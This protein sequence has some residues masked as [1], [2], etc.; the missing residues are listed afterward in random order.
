[1]K[2]IMIIML[3]I[4]AGNVNA[5][6]FKCIVDGKSQYQSNPCKEEKHE[7][8]LPIRTRDI[9]AQLRAKDAERDFNLRQLEEGMLEAEIAQRRAAAI[10]EAAW[11]QR[12][13][14]EAEARMREAEAYER[15]V[16]I[17]RVASEAR[18][19]YLYKEA[20]MSPTFKR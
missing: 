20:G 2:L 16:E 18:E 8:A 11:A 15:Q 7:T 1:M 14:A 17:N 9:K 6:I 19:K 12:Q 4:V 5:D 10:N 13:A 3:A